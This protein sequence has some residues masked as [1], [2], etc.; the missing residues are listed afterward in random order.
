[1][2]IRQKKKA[3]TKTGQGDAPKKRATPK[4]SQPAEEAAPTGDP[5]RNAW[6]TAL[7]AFA[8]REQPPRATRVFLDD[9]FTGP[10]RRAQVDAIM[11]VGKSAEEAVEAVLEAAIMDAKATGAKHTSSL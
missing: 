7:L 2:A 9:R 4:P 3:A 1:M 11:F 6:R 10:I 8:R 5:R